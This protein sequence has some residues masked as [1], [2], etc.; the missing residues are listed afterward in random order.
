[1][2]TRVD[3]YKAISITEVLSPVFETQQDTISNIEPDKVYWDDPTS[4]KCLLDMPDGVTVRIKGR[5]LSTEEAVSVYQ[6]MTVEERVRYQG[7]SDLEI[8]ES[9]Y[10]DPKIGPNYL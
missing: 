9:I 5:T 6:E 4:L 2:I 10:S 3:S 7:L 1:M 8:I